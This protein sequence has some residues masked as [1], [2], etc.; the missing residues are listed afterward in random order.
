MAQYDYEASHEE[1]IGVSKSVKIP[2]ECFAEDRIG[3]EWREQAIHE[4]LTHPSPMNSHLSGHLILSAVRD[5]DKAGATV[6]AERAALLRF[7]MHDTNDVRPLIEHS[8]GY[9][10]DGQ[11]R[12]AATL[13]LGWFGGEWEGERIELV[14]LP[15]SGGPCIAV[16]DSIPVMHRF[17]A[18]IADRVQRPLGRALRFTGA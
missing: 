3:G 8:L 2:L 16:A 9:A 1:K 18:A 13:A 10:P 5:Q 17:L 6:M 4:V 7:L 15:H 14:F 11:G 12:S